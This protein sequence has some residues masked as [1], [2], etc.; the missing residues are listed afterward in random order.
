MATTDRTEA[1]HMATSLTSQGVEGIVA[2]R[3]DSRYRPADRSAWIKWRHT[4]TTDVSIVGIVGPT[5]RPHAVVV[6]FDDGTR[7]VTSPRL[8]PLEARLVTEAVTNRLGGPTRT[9]GGLVVHAVLDGPLAEV[10]MGTG[11]HAGT[12][13]FRIR[14]E[15]V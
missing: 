1:L 11:R 12:H 13:F 8:T 3:L 14:N 2:K 4:E 10:R 5:T 7:A 6:E 15:E 9:T